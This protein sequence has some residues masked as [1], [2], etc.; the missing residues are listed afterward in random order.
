MDTG[1]PS[2]TTSARIALF[3]YG[4]ALLLLT[5]VALG[6]TLGGDGGD[7]LGPK[8]MAVPLWVLALGGLNALYRRPTVERRLTVRSLEHTLLHALMFCA[9]LVIMWWL[10]ADVLSEILRVIAI[11]GAVFVPWRLWEIYRQ[12]L[13]TRDDRRG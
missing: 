2:P 13:D 1:S 10:P 7:P 5:F 9:V 4:A 12:I 11:L 8:L 6:L 3:N